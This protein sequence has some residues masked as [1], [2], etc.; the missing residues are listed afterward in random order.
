VSGMHRGPTR[1]RELVIALLQ[2]LAQ[3]LLP[4]GANCLR[5]TQDLVDPREQIDDGD[6]QPPGTCMRAQVCTTQ[7]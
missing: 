1:S 5:D 2:T 4:C 6:F 7:D 3:F